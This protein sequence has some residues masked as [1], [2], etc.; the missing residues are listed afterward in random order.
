MKWIGDLVGVVL[1]LIGI[2]W[3]LQGT[4]IVPVGFMSRQGQWAIIGF[5][6]GVVGVGLL[7]YVNRRLGSRP[8][9]TG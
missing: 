9:A 5:V 3:I 2:F 7:V 4:G 8:R 6:L 1:T